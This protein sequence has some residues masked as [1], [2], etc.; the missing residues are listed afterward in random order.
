MLTYIKLS[1]I[2]SLWLSSSVPT[3]PGLAQ[4]KPG[5]EKDKYL[6][7]SKQE[8]L[9]KIKGGWAGQTIGVTFGWP[10]EFVYQGT[11]IQDYQ[12]IKWHD[13]YVSEAMRTF[14]GLFDD[15]YMDLTFVEVF[16]RHGLQAP[17]D[18]FAQAYANAGYELW[19][20]NQAGRYNILQGMKAPQSGHWLHNPHADDIDFQIEADFAGLMSPAM[21]NVASSISDKI[22]HIMNYGDGW[23]GGVFVANMYAQAFRSKDI[24]F[25]VTEALKAIPSQS[26]FYQCI[27]DVIKWHQLYPTDW[28]RTW[29]EIQK[30][31]TEEVGCPDGV[32]HPL[33]IDAKLNAAYV[34][35]G[36]LYGKGDF[37]KTMEISTRAGQDS[38]CNPSTAGGVL[39][40]MLGYS[41]IPA[42]WLD[43]LKKAEHLNFSHTSLSLSKVYELGFKHALEN[44][45]FHK[46]KVSNTR[47]DI[48]L[49]PVRTV[50]LEQSFTGH[51][52]R[53]K[54]AIKQS[55]STGISFK[56]KGIGF[57]LRG[58]VQKMNKEAPN[59][60]IQVELYVDNKLVE[61]ANLPVI[62][63]HRRTELCWR[64][65]L[66]DKEHDVQLKVVNPDKDY[67][68]VAIE[69]VEYAGSK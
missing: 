43:P 28:K 40:T 51:H 31:W 45:L 69:V 32:F 53:S 19:H 2:L 10:T 58:Y 18:S 47:V 4:V 66:S 57:V 22:G 60:P 42:Y 20:A 34:V 26:T 37:T 25:I 27:A 46:G 65:Q 23:Y 5:K 41:A 35:L 54:Q 15:I 39:G 67:E 8:L 63:A 68:I 3:G 14:P 38:D 44:I 55:S 12:P 13:D 50:A 6:S 61:V 33:N 9:D 16:E 49:E 59:N 29:F 21:P 7:I 17:V 11:F 30:K 48:P 52:P 24:N 1:L 64:Y 36:L 62:S 56:T